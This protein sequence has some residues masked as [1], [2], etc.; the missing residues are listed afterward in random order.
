MSGQES[1]GPFPALGEHK[2]A[3]RPEFGA[4][5]TGLPT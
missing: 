2:E 4:T 3:I 1:M 5:R